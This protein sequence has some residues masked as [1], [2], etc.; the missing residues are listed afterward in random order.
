M[1][2][3]RKGNLTCEINVTQKFTNLQN[4]QKINNMAHGEIGTSYFTF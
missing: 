1:A 4:I 3:L 2:P